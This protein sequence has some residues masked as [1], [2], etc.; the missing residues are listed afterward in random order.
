MR[1]AWRGADLEGE[2]GRE[3]EEARHAVARLVHG[4]QR[5]F[6]AVQV[7]GEQLEQQAAAHARGV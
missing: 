6:E 7:R 2:Q 5:G 3:E 4:A 1:A